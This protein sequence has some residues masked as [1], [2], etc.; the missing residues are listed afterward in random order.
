MSLSS[1]T[2]EIG[3]PVTRGAWLQPATGRP[4][5]PRWGLADGIQF[6][7]APTPGPRGLLRIYTPYL[8]HPRERLVNFIAVEPIPEGA[9]AR[10]F[11]ELEPSTLDPDARG[12]RMWSADSLDSAHAPK[13]PLDPSP[14]VIDR[15]DGAER[16]TVWVGVE[17]FDNGAH[18][19]V[20]VRVRA[21]RPHEV[22]VA[23]F[24]HG[25]SVA[26]H[27]LILTATMGNWAR[28]RH[29]H[30]DGRTV[31]PR[32]LWPGFER[33]DFTEHG[34]FPLAELQRDGEAAVVTAVGDEADPV[35]V[36]YS[37]DTNAHWHFEGRRAVQGWR[38]DD[39]HRDLEVRV[40]GRWAY[41]AS[42]SPIPGGVAYENFEIVEPFRQGAAF[43]F[44]VVPIG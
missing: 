23:G 5:E 39:P 19:A 20:R 34:T 8:D 33:T 6:G 11:S 42:A 16:L 30:L 31:H 4:A 38:V 40:N 2:P 12:K 26:L 28:L 14:G 25:D 21:D 18:V 37:E 43:R 36:T 24:A 32:D 7:L 13:D 9:D 17:R 1:P 41:W 15:V 29:L 10:G 44:S 22:E 35:G 27:N 3:L